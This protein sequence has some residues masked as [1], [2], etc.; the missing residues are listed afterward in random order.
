MLLLLLTGAR[1]GRKGFGG[2][3]IGRAVWL[4]SGVGFRVRCGICGQRVSSRHG[5]QRAD[6][7]CAR[8]N[9]GLVL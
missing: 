9:G 1:R 3:G 7:V 8:G 4:A 2:F 5:R 6:R